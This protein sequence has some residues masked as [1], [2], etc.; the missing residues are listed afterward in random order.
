MISFLVNIG[1]HLRKKNNRLGYATRFFLNLAKNVGI[2]FQRPRLLSQQVF[3][4]GNRSVSIIA[5]AGLFVGLALA[6]QL[7][8]VLN[9]F[10]SEQAV[11]YSV[12]LSLLREMGPVITALLFTGRA[13][14]ALTA[15]IGLMKA[16]E[17]LIALEMMA[18]D[19]IKRILAPRF[20]AGL[21]S[22][23]LLTMMFNMVGI[24]GAYAVGV[25]MIGIDEGV[26]WSTMQDGV[27]IIKDIGSSL[28]KSIVFGLLICSIALF[29]G[30]EAKPTPEG[31]AQATTNTVIVAS[32]S[33]LGF[34]FLL[35]A[36]M[37]S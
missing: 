33:I 14:T 19:P 22:L 27:S 32:L 5:I 6:L 25:K 18:I 29:Q 26:F 37:F 8:Y 11:G 13:G 9:R 36:L 21:I 16:G 23:P 31:V 24:L 2:I 4:L 28:L 34:N 17:Q 30:Y 20:W 15:E 12:A 1:S 7:Y 10:N 3:F 35:T